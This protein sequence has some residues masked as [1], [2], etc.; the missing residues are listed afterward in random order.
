MPSGNQAGILTKVMNSL[1]STPA[2]AMT[3]GE[4]PTLH[5][6]YSCPFC[7]KV[8]GLIEHL[9]LDVD[10]VPVN[11]MKIRK[12][13]AFAGDW[14]KVPVF[15]DEHGQHIVDSTPL[16]RH[17]DATYNEGKLADRGDAARQDQWMTWVDTHLSKATVPIL[18]GSLGSALKTTTGFRKS[19]NLD[20]SQSA[21]TLGLDSQSCG[22]SSPES[23]SRE[24]GAR[25]RNSG[26][27]C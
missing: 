7:W 21:C 5:M 1:D 23:V 20:S 17:I 13:V 6:L 19:K 22:G 14:G 16:L 3:M 26:T 11:G 27:T 15:T 8:R 4:R 12:E 9:D 10:Y 24:T 25:Q 2:S 18:Y